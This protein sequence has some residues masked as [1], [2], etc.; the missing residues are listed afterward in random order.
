MKLICWN[1]QG[2]GSP[3]TIQSLQALVAQE[4][5]MVLCLLETKNREDVVKR[6][7]KRLKF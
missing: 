4:K 2:L 6:M 3:L 5:P 7:H 1:C